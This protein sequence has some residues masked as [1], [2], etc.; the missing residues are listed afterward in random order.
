MG[1]YDNSTQTGLPE[2]AGKMRHAGIDRNHLVE[3]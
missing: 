2:G 1:V 3:A